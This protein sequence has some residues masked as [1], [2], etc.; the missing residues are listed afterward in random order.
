MAGVNG[1][2]TF[3]RVRECFKGRQVA[4]ADA[5]KHMHGRASPV[6]KPGWARYGYL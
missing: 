1:A 3:V 4:F 6:R 2:A 5:E